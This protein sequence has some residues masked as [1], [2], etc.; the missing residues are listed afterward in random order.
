MSTI[1]VTYELGAGLGH[2][3]RLIAVAE[4]VQ[5]DHN[6]V[7]ALPDRSLGEPIVR[8]AFGDKAR[9]LEG[10]HWPVPNDPNIRKIPTHTFAD[11]IAIIGFNEGDKLSAKTAHWYTILREVAP[12]LIIADFA[13]TLRLAIGGKLPFVVVGNGYTIPPRGQLLP[14][15]RQWETSVSAR[16]RANEGRL[17][18][19][20]N[21]VRAQQ[22]GEAIDFFSDLFS[23]E[24]TFVCTLPEFDPYRRFRRGPT[25]WPFNIP[26][27]PLGPLAAQRSGP[28]IFV[29]LPA[30]H[31]ALSV[32]ISALN[33][34]KVPSA[35]YVPGMTPQQLAKRCR[36]TVRIHGK[37]ADL[38]HV[39]PNTS[40]LI[41]HGGLGT[42]YAGL[43]GGVPQLLMPFNLEHSITAA[44]LEQFGVG[45]SRAA[46][47]AADA[48]D[49][50]DLISSLLQ[51][52]QL[53][54]T[55]MKA[56]GSLAARRAIDPISEVVKACQQHL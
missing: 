4:R 34:L 49:M 25:L 47:A 23:G 36:P 8:R 16:S 32:I 3:N 51:D 41:H 27:V 44:G 26:D 22:R 6:W 46:S 21:I 42:A 55:A 2:L 45:K 43:L 37:P 30:N 1:L 10:V 12:T 35:I 31:P 9:V 13:P 54:E 29:Y 56:A 20:V 52:G 24:H 28:T 7:F 15:I 19:A 53:Q 33:D 38:A 14:P 39:L 48:T 11:V 50:R 40:L 5:G 17:L 18:A